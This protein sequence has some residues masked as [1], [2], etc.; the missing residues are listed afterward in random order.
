M[1]DIEI[2]EAEALLAAEPFDRDEIGEGAGVPLPQAGQSLRPAPGGDRR[3]TI[4]YEANFRAISD[5]RHTA[6]ADVYR[7]RCD[8]SL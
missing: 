7:E 2:E 1:N 3:S 5:H 6:R 8:H 4:T